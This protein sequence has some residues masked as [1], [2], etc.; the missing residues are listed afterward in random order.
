MWKDIYERAF[1]EDIRISLKNMKNTR[2]DNTVLIELAGKLKKESIEPT[3]NSYKYDFEINT[4]KNE[5]NYKSS[6]LT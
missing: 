6:N 2:K 1:N 3:Q 5:S 4:Q